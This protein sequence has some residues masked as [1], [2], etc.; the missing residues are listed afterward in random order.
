MLRLLPILLA[1]CGWGDVKEDARKFLELC[2]ASKFAEARAE[3]GPKMAEALTTEKL[4]Q[5]WQ[6][7]EKQLGPITEMGEPREDRVGVSRRAK[8]RCQFK[9]TALDALV[10]FDPQG[11]IEG[12]FLLPA[13]D[14]NAKKPE[15]P[16][17]DPSKYVEEEVVVGAE[18]W[19][20]AG[21]LTR[22]KGV[23][24]A[25]LA[26]LL[27]GSGPH[28]RDETIGPN[29]PFRDLAH[30]LASRG[31]AVLRFEKRTHAHK[32]RYADPKVRDAVAVQDE[33]VDDAL[34]AVARA[35]SWKGIDPDRIV[36]LGHSLG[37]TAAPMVAKQ[38]GR[39]AGVV[40]LA[41]SARPA[42]E[43]VRDQ[44]DHIKRVD[45]DRAKALAD[46]DSNLD[47]RLA[48]MKSGEAKDD[49]TL[50]GVP[51]RYWKTM[52]AAHPDRL[53][54]ELPTLPVLVL[55]GGRDYQVTEA[56]F[57]LFRRALDGR[58]NAT[59]KLYPDL[60]HGFQPGEG[61]AVPAEYEKPGFVDVRVIDDVAAWVRSLP[62][63]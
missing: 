2:Q 43:M 22:P 62:P 10:S 42:A 19:P 12:F 4:A 33:V 3:F 39:L 21:T 56:D 28:D 18:G 49:E 31:M 48:R 59:L 24:K 55:Q 35:R 54:A 25:P 1:T 27:H 37:G 30:G 8:I 61:K 14:E 7:L 50:L 26:I 63:R 9:T 46:L 23:E 51:V 15:P 16:Y 34:A 20:L 41:A 11:R 45:P 17:A 58:P 36:V 5:L 53:L 47:D 52:D 32:E 38:D 57:D 29:A 13:A 40:L 6:G 60:N 44:V